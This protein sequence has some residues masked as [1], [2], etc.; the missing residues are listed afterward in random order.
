MSPHVIETV[1]FKLKD[2]ITKDAFVE[3]LDAA[4][5]FITS[6]PG[7]IA[8]RL[9]CTADGTWIE[10]IEWESMDH[11]KAAAAQIGSN[12]DASAMVQA[13]SG[14]SVTLMHSDLAVSIG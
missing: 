3:T 13:I 11:A 5:R 8:R 14:E 10:H 4:N 9:S 7:F 6:C 12:S 2:G 1:L